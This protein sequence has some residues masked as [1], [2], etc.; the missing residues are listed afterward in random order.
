MYG[1]RKN[2]RQG[3]GM[4]RRPY[5]KVRKAQTQPSYSSGEMPKCMPKQL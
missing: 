1:K 4:E 3:G 2:K 5:K